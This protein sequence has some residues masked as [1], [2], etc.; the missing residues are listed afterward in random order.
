MDR[1]RQKEPQEYSRT[2]SDM[3]ASRLVLVGLKEDHRIANIAGGVRTNE[4]QRRLNKIS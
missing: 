4:E 1:S 2:L 3:D